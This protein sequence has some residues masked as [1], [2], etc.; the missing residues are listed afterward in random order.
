MDSLLNPNRCI[1]YLYVNRQGHSK[2]GT[3]ARFASDDDRAANQLNYPQR[4]SENK[5]IAFLVVEGY[6]SLIELIKNLIHN[7]LA[8][9]P[10]GIGHLYSYRTRVRSL[11]QHDVARLEKFDD[12]GQQVLPSRDDVAQYSF[13]TT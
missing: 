3:F 1:T 4:K 10:A 9:T 11:G 8:H 6:S 7:R 12:V 2:R 5:P 13:L